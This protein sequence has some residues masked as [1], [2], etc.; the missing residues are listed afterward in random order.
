MWSYSLSKLIEVGP[1]GVFAGYPISF[2][3]ESFG[4]SLFFGTFET[5]KG[6]IYKNYVRYLHNGETKSK[7]LY[8]SFILAAGALASVSVQVVHY[9]L[10]KFQKLHLMRLEALDEI[11]KHRTPESRLSTWRVYSN[12]YV[13]TFEQISKLVSK[14]ASG[15]WFKWFYGGFFRATL[16]TMPSTSIGLVVFEIM[17]LR[18]AVEDF[19]DDPPAFHS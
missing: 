4:Y 8:P 11:N 13:H 1:R 16:A 5:V 2:L 3:K 12:T 10:G 17:R 7:V 19:D 18:Y 9:P 6:P 14:N 15:S